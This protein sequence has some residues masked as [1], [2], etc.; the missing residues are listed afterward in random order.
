MVERQSSLFG[1]LPDHLAPV[2]P[3][4]VGRRRLA[5][6]QLPLGLLPPSLSGEVWRRSG[7][8]PWLLAS[9]FGRVASEGR[10]RRLPPRLVTGAVHPN[11][12]IVGGDGIYRC[13]VVADAW[14][15]ARPKGAVV[16]HLDG[17]RDNDRPENVTWGTS[18]QNALDRHGHGTMRAVLT[19]DA[20]VPI[21]RAMKRGT[22]PTRLGRKFGVTASA[23]HC[24]Q[25]GDSW[26]HIA[27]RM[28]RRAKWIARHLHCD[29]PI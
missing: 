10:K 18:S 22:S 24:V 13:C 25:S 29:D 4:R 17:S 27:P 7:R 12:Y 23:I 11:G 6:G 21:L 2:W 20:V 28:D 8:W 19:A 9:N 26:R 5:D 16:R 14:H 3:A 15:G 1:D